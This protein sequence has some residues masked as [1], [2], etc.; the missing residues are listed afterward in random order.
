MFYATLITI[1]NKVSINTNNNVLNEIDKSKK[2]II[3]TYF[4]RYVV[5]ISPSKQSINSTNQP[6]STVENFAHR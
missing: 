4:Y 1:K 5:M 2:K 6:R 3:N